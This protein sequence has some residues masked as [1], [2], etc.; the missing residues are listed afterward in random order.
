MWKK[1]AQL[2]KIS[3]RSGVAGA[4][5][6]HLCS[7]AYSG[8]NISRPGIAVPSRYFPH[9]RKYRWNCLSTVRILLQRTT[10]QTTFKYVWI[11]YQ[12]SPPWHLGQLPLDGSVY[13]SL[14]SNFYLVHFL[15]VGTVIYQS[16]W[17]GPVESNG[18]LGP[19]IKGDSGYPQFSC[20]TAAELWTALSL[21]ALIQIGFDLHDAM[22][23]GGW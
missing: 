15:W 21:K 5:F 10:P 4:I 18:P 23:T 11:H 20:F 8:L 14:I 13:Y 12:K 19:H 1:N 22:F 17:R 9:Q 7:G 3:T 2:W 16:A 6:F